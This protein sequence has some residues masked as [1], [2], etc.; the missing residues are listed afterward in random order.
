VLAFHSQLL[1]HN[2]L[3][4]LLVCVF[5]AFSVCTVLHCVVYCHVLQAAELAAQLEQFKQMVKD[6]NVSKEE[7]DELRKM[8]KGMD[9][10]CILTFMFAIVCYC[11]RHMY[12]CTIALCK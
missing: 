8:F 5:S 6:D 12:V 10:V 4:M 7:V 9:M 2:L 11:K 1:P 3:L